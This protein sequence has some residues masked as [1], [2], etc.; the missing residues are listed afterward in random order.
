MPADYQ[1]GAFPLDSGTSSGANLERTAAREY[2]SEL[3]GN[4]RRTS[5]IF[6]ETRALGKNK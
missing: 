3:Q 4:F 2:L 6:F 1:C 5:E